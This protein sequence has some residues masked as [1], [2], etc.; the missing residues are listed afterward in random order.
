MFYLIVV[1][2]FF[3]LIQFGNLGFLHF[4]I[5]PEQG[6][7]Y[8][9]LDLEFVRSDNNSLTSF[10]FHLVLIGRIFN[11]TLDK[12]LFNAFDDTTGVL[13]FVY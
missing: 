11:L 13:N 6:R 2:V 10:N 3:H 8:F 9:F 4:R 12:S 5:D 1:S 7:F